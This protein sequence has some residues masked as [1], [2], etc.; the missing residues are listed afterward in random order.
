MSDIDKIKAINAAALEAVRVGDGEKSASTYDEK[1]VMMPPNTPL[2]E[3][4]G[5]IGQHFNNL[6]PDSTVTASTP[7]IEVSG[8]L[9]YQLYRVT[10]ESDGK[11]KYTDCFDVLKQQD[12]GSWLYVASAWNSE[13]GF[14][15]V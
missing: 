8:N 9:A 2:V 13:D 15:Q 12:D 3:G 7:K 4:R 11:T 1:G 14:D 10:W 6:G 5:A